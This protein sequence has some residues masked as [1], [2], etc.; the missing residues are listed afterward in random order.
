MRSAKAESIEGQVQLAML[1]KKQERWAEFENKLKALAGRRYSLAMEALGRLLYE[2]KLGR[3]PS[4]MRST[5][6]Y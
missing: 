3:V 5:I 2:G 4:R 6:S 1:Y